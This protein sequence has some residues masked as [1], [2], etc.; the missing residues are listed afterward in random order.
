[1]DFKR[2]AQFIVIALIVFPIF[3]FA[4]SQDYLLVTFDYN[5]TT[6]VFSNISADQRVIDP[7][8]VAG[9]DVGDYTMTLE[10]SQ[11]VL[12]QAK[13]FIPDP[14]TVATESLGNDTDGYGSPKNYSATVELALSRSV[15]ASDGTITISHNGQVLLSQKLSDTPIAILKSSSNSVIM[16]ATEPSFPPYPP[17][18]QSNS[19]VHTLLLWSPLPLLLIILIATWWFLKKRSTNID[20]A[21]PANTPPIV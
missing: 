1:M 4:S 15:Q 13:F 9:Q 19:F 11:G 10:D 3:A 8:S 6:H 14:T 17:M 16:P 7:L 21:P 18:P 20:A 2:I 12:S 5:Y